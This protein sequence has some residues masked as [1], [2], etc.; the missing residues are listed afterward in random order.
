[1]GL[2]VRIPFGLLVDTGELVDVGSVDRG[3]VCNCICPSCKTPLIA[4]QG[5]LKEWHFAHRSQ[6]IHDKTRQECDFSFALSVRLMIRQLAEKGL[7][8]KTPGL[9]REIYAFSKFTQQS[10]TFVYHVAKESTLKL[11]NINVGVSFSGVQVDILGLIKAVP[12]VLY[13][14]YKGRSVPDELMHPC[15]SMC[16]IL[17]LNVEGIPDLFKEAKQGKYIEALRHYIEDTFIGKKWIYHPREEK[18]LEKVKYDKECWL[19]Q[20]LHNRGPII[21]K[22]RDT[23]VPQGSAYLLPEPKMKPIEVL[24]FRDYTCVICKNQWHSNSRV[25]EKCGTQIYTIESIG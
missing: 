8:L 24:P 4:R 9:K 17:E 22:S 3:R 1:M 11:E 5:E 19:T 6:K 21:I 7:T 10:K 25:C 18:A 23:Q 16:G 2:D 12:F 20:Q 15:E 13:V 14:T